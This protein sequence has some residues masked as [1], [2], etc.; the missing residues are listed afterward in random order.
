MGFYAGCC[1]GKAGRV[2]GEEPGSG[3]S[4]KKLVDHRWGC[5]GCYNSVI[6]IVFIFKVANMSS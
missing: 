2:N 1:L 5:C 4:M 3:A 6:S